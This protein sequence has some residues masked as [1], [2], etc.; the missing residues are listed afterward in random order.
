MTLD[1][2]Y[3]RM[4]RLN[5]LYCWCEETHDTLW[6]IANRH[7]KRMKMM[8]SEEPYRWLNPRVEG[9]KN[10]SPQASSMHPQQAPQQ[11]AATDQNS[12]DNV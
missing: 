4:K 2:I 5:F 7:L 3:Y 1:E 8:Y 6:P 11:S 10:S 9:Y 12:A